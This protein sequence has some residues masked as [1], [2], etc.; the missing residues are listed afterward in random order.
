M[1]L[2]TRGR[3]QSPQ[4][5]DL[6]TQIRGRKERGQMTATKRRTAVA[7]EVLILIAFLLSS[8]RPQP[9]SR[10]PALSSFRPDHELRR[11]RRQADL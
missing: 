3:G 9:V 8:H 4:P 5:A 6:T 1:A 10:P 7:T 11:R 2:D